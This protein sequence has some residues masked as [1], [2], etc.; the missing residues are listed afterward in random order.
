MFTATD[1]NLFDSIS[2][3]CNP[4]EIEAL[5]E[6]Y[7]GVNTQA[8]MSKKHWNSVLVNGD[9][10]DEL[11]YKWIDQS[12]ELVVSKMSKKMQTELFG[13]EPS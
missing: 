2:V 12:Y 4:D 1:I 8:Y 3:K 7:A 9:V 6:K 5:R 10:P 13:N 11:I